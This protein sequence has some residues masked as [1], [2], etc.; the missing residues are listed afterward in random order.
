[1]YEMHIVSK[2]LLTCGSGVFN[3]IV[4]VVLSLELRNFS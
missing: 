1:M 3:I 4:L 2:N